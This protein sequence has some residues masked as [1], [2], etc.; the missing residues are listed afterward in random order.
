MSLRLLTRFLALAV[1]AGVFALTA[2]ACGDN[3]PVV[4]PTSPPSFNESQLTMGPG[5]KIDLVIYFGQNESK[6]TYTLDSSGEIAVRYIGTV[7]AAGKTA[8]QLKD[9]IQAKLADG[10]LKEPIVS[11]TVSE[12]NSRKLSVLG[13]VSRS[14]TIK[15]VPG[16]TITDAIAQSGGFTPMARKNLVRVTRSLEDGKT[17]TWELPV[18]KIGEGNR[19]T[20]WVMPGDIVFVPERVF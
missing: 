17:V 7:D 19:P 3:P 18:E 5:D 15:F 14:G 12:I 4:Y 1:V 10:Y 16:M 13:Q 8:A 2:A 9:E 6:A 11:V 20:F